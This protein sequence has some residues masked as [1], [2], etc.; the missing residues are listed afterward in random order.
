VASAT[1]PEHDRHRSV[2]AGLA[3][4]AGSRIPAPRLGAAREH[5]II[6]ALAEH[7][8][9]AAADTAHQGAGPDGRGPAAAS[10]AARLTDSRPLCAAAL[11]SYTS[12]QAHCTPSRA[13]LRIRIAPMRTTTTH[14]TPEPSMSP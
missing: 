4:K 9:L 14:S 8:I 3:S 11:V 13:T 6:D 5:G 1:Q 10:T 12:G 7:E 2:V